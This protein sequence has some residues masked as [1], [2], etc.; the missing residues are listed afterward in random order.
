MSANQTEKKKTE[1]AKTG[2]DALISPFKK[3]NSK[4]VKKIQNRTYG[5]LDAL[6][7][8]IEDIHG[9]LMESIVIDGTPRAWGEGGGRARNLIPSD[10]PPLLEGADYYIKDENSNGVF[11]LA[12]IVN[13][14][15]TLFVFKNCITGT[16][17]TFTPYSI[18]DLAGK[19][20][21]I[22]MMTPA[23]VEEYRKKY[24]KGHII[25]S[26]GPKKR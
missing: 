2:T 13:G 18:R 26:L 1:P 21:C 25:A 22:K 16:R 3:A 10:I 7:A 24:F 20:A 19:H 6:S 9:S 4:T 14:R 15:A 8:D 12:Q 11:T 23:E 5:E 17:T